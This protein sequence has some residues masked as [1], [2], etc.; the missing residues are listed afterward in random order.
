[1]R[2]ASARLTGHFSTDS[3]P[4]Q[5]AMRRVA[6]LEHERLEG[7]AAR[8]RALAGK[9]TQIARRVEQNLALQRLQAELTA[10][11]ARLQ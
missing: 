11:R 8:L 1:M 5:A 2:F 7:E 10:V 6:L 3:T 4:D 9:E